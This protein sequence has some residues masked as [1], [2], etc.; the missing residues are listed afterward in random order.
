VAGDLKHELSVAAFME[1]APGRG[2]FHRETAKNEGSGRESE[3]LL[4][5]FP[6]LPDQPNGLRL[7]EPTFRNDQTRALSA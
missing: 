3:I 6:I 2:P 4:F 1:K 5:A 7:A